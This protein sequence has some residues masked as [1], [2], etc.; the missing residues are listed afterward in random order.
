MAIPDWSMEAEQSILGAILITPDEFDWVI[1]RLTEQHFKAPQNQQV[2]YAIKDLANRQLEIDAFSVAEHCNLAAPEMGL[3]SYIIDLG[4]NTL[5][6]SASN[7]RAY[8]RSLDE[9]KKRREINQAVDEIITANREA[10]DVQAVIATAERSLTGL[11]AEL[12]A[13][14]TTFV[15]AG[16]RAIEAIEERFHRPENSLVGVPT[17]LQALDDHTLGLDRGLY[18]LA[19]RPSMG[20][21]AFAVNN[22]ALATA[23]NGGDVAIFSLE[24]EDQQLAER[25]LAALGGVDYGRIRSAKELTQEDFQGLAKAIELMNVLPVEFFEQSETDA[26]RIRSNIRTWHRRVENPSLVVIDYLQ[27]MTFSG[28]GNKTDQIGEATRILK[29]LSKELKIPILLLSQL[30]RSLEQRPNKRPINSDLRDSGSIEQDADGIFFIYRDEVYDDQ[31]PYTGIAELIIGKYRNGEAGKIFMASTLNR[32]KFSDLSPE[33]CEPE[34]SFS[35][36]GRI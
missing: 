6:V 2:I 7:V 34:K 17:G 20:K 21:T 5:G 33:W 14:Y 25:S 32:Q 1:D 16:K 8:M 30:N 26:S 28:V 15:D 3:M 12:Q 24:M 4:E 35:R 36:R 29:N 27:L 10:K 31:S 11:S 19:A 23:K 9:Y 13:E 22:V 18:I